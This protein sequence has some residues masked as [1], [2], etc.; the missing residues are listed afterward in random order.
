ME[1]KG[2]GGVYGTVIKRVNQNNAAFPDWIYWNACYAFSLMAIAEQYFKI[3]IPVY[4]KLDLM[5]D[6]KDKDILADDC[7][8]NDTDRLLFETS[9]YFYE[10]TK[11][12]LVIFKIFGENHFHNRKKSWGILEGDY[13]VR[14][15]M[16]L[17]GNH[18]FQFGDDEARV[19]WDPWYPERQ[20]KYEISA[21]YFQITRSHGNTESI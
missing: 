10:R 13:T 21:R 6:L 3:G 11:N 4:D 19:A 17:A 14:H 1:I 15:I 7:Y 9:Q 8:V 18:H 16:T 20:A 2:P 12:D 5:G